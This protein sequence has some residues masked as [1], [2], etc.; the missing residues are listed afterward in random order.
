MLFIPGRRNG[1][2][3]SVDFAVLTQSALLVHHVRREAKLELF[4]ER[5]S[6]YREVQ[7]DNCLF[8]A[9]IAMPRIRTLFNTYLS[10]HSW[11]TSLLS[12][13]HW[14]VHNGRRKQTECIVSVLLHQIALTTE[15][16]LFYP[17]SKAG[18]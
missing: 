18:D 5:R 10:Q 6:C 15:Q 17:G 11:T 9:R 4:N 13:G 8:G 1:R 12:L 16:L 3:W 7:L 2:L 14:P